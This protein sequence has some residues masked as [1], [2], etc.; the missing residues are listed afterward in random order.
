M[1]AIVSENEFKTSETLI[2]MNKIVKCKKCISEENLCE[3][4][5]IMIKTSIIN[6]VRNWIK[7][8]SKD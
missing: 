5:S 8:S 6:D 3:S 1:K 2:V 4:H 7:F